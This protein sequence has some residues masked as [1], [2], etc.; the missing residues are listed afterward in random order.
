MYLTLPASTIE[1]VV[2]NILLVNV[3]YFALLVLS[4]LA[5]YALSICMLAPMFPIEN[6]SA[7]VCFKFIS[8]SGFGYLAILLT[9]GA[10]AMLFAS[11][12]FK[13]L[14]LLWS[15]LIGVAM[16]FVTIAI[17]IAISYMADG[18]MPRSWSLS[19]GELEAMYDVILSLVTLFFWFMTWLRLRETE[20]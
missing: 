17:N 2:V 18:N 15:F 1:K 6:V 16:L 10:A 5:G 14:A 7:F 12:Y 9:A 19:Y 3:Y 20:V 4:G 8:W 11:V 13:K